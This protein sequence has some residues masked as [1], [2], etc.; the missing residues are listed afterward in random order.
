MLHC[1]SGSRAAERAAKERLALAKRER[2][3]E[4]RRA[5]PSPAR[6]LVVGLVERF[7]IEPFPDFS[8]K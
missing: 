1:R 4:Q 6:V 2:V 7:D 5:V 8:V 3:A